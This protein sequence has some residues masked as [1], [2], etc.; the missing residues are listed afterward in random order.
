MQKE[1]EVED[2][3]LAIPG[4]TEETV[5]KISGSISKLGAGSIW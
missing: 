5:A 1:K 3:L 4:Q 2:L